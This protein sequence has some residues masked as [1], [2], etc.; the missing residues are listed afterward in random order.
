[1]TVQFLNPTHQTGHFVAIGSYS[2]GAVPSS[3][4]MVSIQIVFALEN[5]KPI[6]ERSPVMF[7]VQVY[8][9]YI[10]RHS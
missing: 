4:C 7:C 6:K 1:M 10:R 9:V 8:V 3:N 5:E 2:V